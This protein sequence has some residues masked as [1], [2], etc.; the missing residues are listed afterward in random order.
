MF[1]TR[2]CSMTRQRLQRSSVSCLMQAICMLYNML[3]MCDMHSCLRR[4][5]LIRPS[6]EHFC[7]L[8]SY[9]KVLATAPTHQPLVIF[10]RGMLCHIWAI[11]NSCP[12]FEGICYIDECTA[13]YNCHAK[14]IPS[15]FAVS[16]WPCT[17]DLFQALHLQNYHYLH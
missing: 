15:S 17:T 16:T 10:E 7:R 11:I 4:L 12:R 9:S 14:L 8:A 13:P 3:C 1:C 5:M 2:S 6:V